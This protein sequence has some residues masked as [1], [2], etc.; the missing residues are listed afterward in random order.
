ME[1]AP[2][3][4]E[5]ALQTALQVQ[6]PP[7]LLAEPAPASTVGKKRQGGRATIEEIEQ[8]LSP[9]SGASAE[10]I[11]KALHAGNT[12]DLTAT[13]GS[14]VNTILCDRMALLRQKAIKMARDTGCSI[15][16]VVKPNDAFGQLK[17]NGTFTTGYLNSFLAE[18]YGPALPWSELDQTGCWIYEHVR[19]LVPGASKKELLKVAHRLGWGEPAEVQMEEEEEEEK[20][21]KRAKHTALEADRTEVLLALDPKSVVPKSVVTAAEKPIVLRIKDMASD[22]FFRACSK[23]VWLQLNFSD[24]RSAKAFPDVLEASST[25][26]PKNCL[27]ALHTFLDNGYWRDLGLSDPRQFF[28]WL[29]GILQDFERYKQ[30]KA[31][32]NTV[33]KEWAGKL[34]PIFIR[35]LYAYGGQ[36]G[37]IAETQQAFE[38]ATFAY[39][40]LGSPPV[41]APPSPPGSPPP[42]LVAFHELPDVLVTR[43]MNDFKY[44]LRFRMCMREIKSFKRFTD[45]AINDPAQAGLT[46][47]FMP[48]IYCL[49]RRSRVLGDLASG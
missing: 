18:S 25:N 39:M 48:T 46:S 35:L 10:A 43:Y 7:A 34:V 40:P 22:L 27:D 17:Q 29:F 41:S 45:H 30:I 28:T 32:L 15:Q 3:P 42:E 47:W 14:N 37:S 11:K 36:H 49:C 12:D 4:L 24:G 20:E 8:D 1:A 38:A 13:E 31:R 16:L 6:P 23:P 2:N 21:A 9:F 44:G 19:G 5:L 26:H 33:K